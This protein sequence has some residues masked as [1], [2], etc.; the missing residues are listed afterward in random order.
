MILSPLLKMITEFGQFSFSLTLKAI[1]SSKESKFDY[2]I[3]Q[4]PGDPIVNI[5]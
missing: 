3:L 2:N 1:H 4:H 5:C